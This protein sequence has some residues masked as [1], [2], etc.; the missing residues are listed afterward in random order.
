MFNEEYGICENVDIIGAGA[1][2]G[3]DSIPIQPPMHTA[4]ATIRIDH[5]DGRI[6]VWERPVGEPIGR[7]FIEVG[8]L[9]QTRDYFIYGWAT[10]TG[11]RV[12]ELWIV[13]GDTTIFALLHPWPIITMPFQEDQRLDPNNATISWTNVPSVWDYRVRV[14]RFASSLGP[15][16]TI[17][18]HRLSG[19]PNAPTSYTI[20]AHLLAD[21]QRYSISITAFASG[22][23]L[24]TVAGEHYWMPL[25]GPRT[26]RIGDIPFEI[27][28]PSLDGQVFDLED[29]NI[30]WLQSPGMQYIISL[31]N[32][33]TNELL[34]NQRTLLTND[35]SFTIPRSMLTAGHRYRVAVGI[36]VPVTFDIEWRERT[37]EIRG[38]QQ[39]DFW[40]FYINQR[41]EPFASINVR[42]AFYIW[43]R[44]CA[45]TCVAMFICRKEGI[46]N[47]RENENR[48]RSVFNAVITHGTQI[49][50][51]LLLNTGRIPFNGRV[52]HVDFLGR[53]Q[54][55]NFSDTLLQHPGHFTLAI[56]N[57]VVKDPGSRAVQTVAAARNLWG[58]EDRWWR[59]TQH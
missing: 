8:S 54:P 26:F 5:G 47:T 52:Y 57:T 21:R 33:T 16:E 38:N 15:S 34:I 10:A 30:S 58:E 51:G 12:T 48:I 6:D 49:G 20:P 43:D 46:A 37:F 32:I 27:T 24:N 36:R 59:L 9:Q 19:A 42:G 31:R 2:I 4:M 56:D 35:T 7:G 50:T 53:T 39:D 13:P 1:S 3:G 25:R 29:R 23:A 44:G 40:R 22:H 45:V 41:D 14:V 55:S 18:D 11:E 17:L 28:N